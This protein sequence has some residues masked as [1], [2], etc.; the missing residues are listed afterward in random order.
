MR[1]GRLAVIDVGDAVELGHLL[2][3]MPSGTEPAEPVT[4]GGWRDAVR[5]GKCSR[6]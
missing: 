2:D 5:T 1:V 4:H 3:A 6:G